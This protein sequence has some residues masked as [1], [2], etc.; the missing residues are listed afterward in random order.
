[1][2]KNALFQFLIGRL[3]TGHYLALKCLAGVF[4]FLIGRLETRSSECDFMKLGV[5]IP[6]GR[7]ETAA[8]SCSCLNSRFNSLIGRLETAASSCPSPPQ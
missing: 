3:E 1:M 5:S 6:H 2:S 8:S 4:Q 7:L